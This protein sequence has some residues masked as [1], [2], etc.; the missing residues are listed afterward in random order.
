[1]GIS[2]KTSRVFLTE[3]PD[4]A[5]YGSAAV[6][7][8]WKT[9]TQWT[10]SELARALSKTPNQILSRGFFPGGLVQHNVPSGRTPKSLGEAGNKTS[11][12]H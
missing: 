12:A 9:E 3:E 2:I 7:G 1:M 6:V 5:V 4:V 10:L 8:E 11:A